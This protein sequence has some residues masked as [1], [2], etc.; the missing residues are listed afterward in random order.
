MTR[1]VRLRSTPSTL[2]ALRWVPRGCAPG[3]VDTWPWCLTLSAA[4]GLGSGPGPRETSELLSHPHPGFVCS[5]TQLPGAPVLSDEARFKVCNH[6]H[7]SIISAENYSQSIHWILCSPELTLMFVSVHFANIPPVFFCLSC[8][9]RMKTFTSK[10]KKSTKLKAINSLYLQ[11][12]S[13]NGNV[14]ITVAVVWWPQCCRWVVFGSEI[15]ARS[16][17]I[18]IQIDLWPLTPS[19]RRQW[20]LLWM[21]GCWMFVKMYFNNK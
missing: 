1:V 16:L 13:H 12:I 14:A 15:Q 3:T 9:I 2:T 11:I 20:F 6:C 19:S 10:K 7:I 21:N 4:P 17:L 8:I 5:G 18:Y